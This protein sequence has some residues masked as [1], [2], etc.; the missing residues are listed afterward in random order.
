MEQHRGADADAIAVHRR[1]QRSLA[2]GK[3]AQE[4]PHRNFFITTGPHLEEV[5][6]IVA[7]GEVLA[8]AAE[9][10]QADGRIRARLLDRVRECGVHR[11]RYRIPPL[12]PRQR[13][14]ED[15]SLPFHPHMVAHVRSRI[16]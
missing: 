10:D 15:G 6:E 11:D 7:G 9:G 8:L 3:H 5:R 1:D 12:R 2:G 4:A 16:G 14:R 13:H